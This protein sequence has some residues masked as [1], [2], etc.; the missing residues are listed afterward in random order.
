D[1]DDPK[2]LTT[3]QAAV[4]DAVGSVLRDGKYELRPALKALFKSAHFYGDAIVGNTIKPPVQCTVG[5]FRGLATPWPGLTALAAALGMMG[6]EL[7]N[8]P[9]VAGWDGGRGWINTSTLFC[10]QNVAAFLISGKLPF[11]DGWSEARVKYDPMFLVQDLA[12]K[13]ARTVV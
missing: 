10:R 4:I 7:F 1:I 9:S 8:P 12:E 2:K 11:D 3:E 13:N 5:T 6:Q